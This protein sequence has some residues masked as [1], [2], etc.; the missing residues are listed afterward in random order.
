M[1]FIKGFRGTILN[2]FDS[3]MAFLCS[4]NL[5]R[6]IWIYLIKALEDLASVLGRVVTPQLHHQKG[7]TICFFFF[8]TADIQNGNFQ[9]LH[10]Q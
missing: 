3:Y 10:K 2:T 6:N 9:R 1:N 7:C 4:I 5:Q 8:F